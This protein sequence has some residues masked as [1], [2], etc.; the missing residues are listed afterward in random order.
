[1]LNL[2]VHFVP[3]VIMEAVLLRE[4]IPPVWAFAPQEVI[5]QLVRQHTQTVPWDGMV[6]H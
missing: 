2:P 1:M 5:A 4:S 3:L 6:Y